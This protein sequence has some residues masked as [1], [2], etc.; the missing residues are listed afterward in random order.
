M[1]LRF[2]IAEQPAP[3]FDWTFNRA[4]LQALIKR[5]DIPARTIPSAARPPTTNE[6]DH[7]Q[8]SAGLRRCTKSSFAIT[9][10][11]RTNG[12]RSSLPIDRFTALSA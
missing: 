7:Y 11:D 12:Y 3:Q 6:L 9:G 1:S 10:A 5:M 4:D 8:S 2:K